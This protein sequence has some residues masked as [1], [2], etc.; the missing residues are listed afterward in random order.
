M[1]KKLPKKLI[2]RKFAWGM[3][4]FAP[5]R[6]Q[7]ALNFHHWVKK[8][9]QHVRHHNV[10]IFLGTI[11]SIISCKKAS[12]HIAP[13]SQ[14]NNKSQTS[15]LAPSLEDI[16]TEKDTIFSFAEFA[17]KSPQLKNSLGALTS[18]D[19]SYLEIGKQNRFAIQ[20]NAR[21]QN[22]LSKVID[23]KRLNIQGSF[24]VDGFA[25][26]NKIGGNGT[27]ALTDMGIEANAQ[28][29][30]LKGHLRFL[31]K[32]R[33]AGILKTAIDQVLTR[34]LGGDALIFGSELLGLKVGG[35]IGGQIGLKA[36][37]DRN[38]DDAAVLAFTPK[39]GLNAG[40]TTKVESLSFSRVEVA[41]LVNLI[42]SSIVNQGTFGALRKISLI[43]GDIGMDSGEFKALDG[44]IVLGAS[45]GAHGE[46]PTNV[47]RNLWTIMTE[48]SAEILKKW[49]VWLPSLK[50]QHHLWDPKPVYVKDLPEFMKPFISFFRKPM[51]SDQCMEKY[52][53]L[54]KFIRKTSENFDQISHQ[55]NDSYEKSKDD[56]QLSRLRVIANVKTN[57][58]MILGKVHEYCINL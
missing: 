19:K 7:I 41:G 21:V 29:L 57:Y 32:D 52:E 4:D 42:D 3:L 56:S 30:H 55:I 14:D 49:G 25:F 10:C 11:F 20:T 43:L 46:L 16:E 22:T 50:W 23:D 36:D 28:D 39:S 2:G 48:K 53:E 24:W 26:N 47:D 13:L 17:A 54:S 5:F 31:G 15:D 1:P 34:E 8:M 18:K 27:G 37:L 35:N 51:T 9:I 6:L 44:K 38:I 12:D 40:I 33:L 45:V 58:Q